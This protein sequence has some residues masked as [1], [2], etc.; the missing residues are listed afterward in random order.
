M[1]RTG[2]TLRTQLS[3]LARTGMRRFARVHHSRGQ[4]SFP[5][6]KWRE[7]RRDDVGESSE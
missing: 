5:G 6:F 7:K 3:L 4:E 2:S 1:V